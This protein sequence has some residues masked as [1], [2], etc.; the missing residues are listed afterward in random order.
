MTSF[1]CS[2]TSSFIPQ[3]T[4]LN[5]HKLI[6]ILGSP[7]NHPTFVLYVLLIR[8]HVFHMLLIAGKK[9]H[10]V[11]AFS[12]NYGMWWRSKRSGWSL[13]GFIP[14]IRPLVAFASSVHVRKYRRLV[15]RYCMEHIFKST[16]AAADGVFIDYIDGTG[17]ETRILVYPRV[18]FNIADEP[19]MQASFVG[20]KIGAMSRM[21]CSVCE[22]VPKEDGVMSEGTL[23][24]ASV[25][26]AIFPINGSGKPIEKH[27]A[28]AL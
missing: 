27:V 5:C 19:E 6:Y 22:V 18:P 17:T 9:L 7:I 1:F 21:P 11:Y 12:F 23:R 14:V 13:L 3:Y 20:S 10:P 26:R 2:I 8:S 4:E 24:D 25:M 15:A 16:I 28:N